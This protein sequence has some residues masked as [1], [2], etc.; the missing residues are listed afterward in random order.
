MSIFSAA[1]ARILQKKEKYFV[2]RTQKERSIKFINQEVGRV[3][4][5]TV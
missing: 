2:R 1:A 3:L 5:A 4:F